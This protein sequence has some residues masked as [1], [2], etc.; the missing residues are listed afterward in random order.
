M[1]EFGKI[2]QDDK[3]HHVFK[4]TNKGNAELVIGEVRASCGCTAA[5][6]SAKNV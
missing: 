5:L 2:A 4:F 6:A 1:R 3:A